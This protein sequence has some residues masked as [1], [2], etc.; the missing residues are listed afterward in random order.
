M[1][2]KSV[3]SF[4]IPVSPN[5]LVVAQAAAEQAKTENEQGHGDV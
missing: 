2:M 3:D 5:M 4:L 1:L